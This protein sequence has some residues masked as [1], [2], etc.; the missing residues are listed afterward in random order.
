[1][2]KRSRDTQLSLFDAVPRT[3]PQGQAS[4]PSPS[5]DA[6]DP[7]GQPGVDGRDEAASTA[8]S[9]SPYL[10]PLRIPTAA[11]SLQ[12]AASAFDEHLGRL[13]KTTNTRRAFASDLRLLAEFLGPARALGGISTDDLNRFLTWML[14]YRGEPCSPKTYDR[15]L[16][17]LKV[18]FGWLHASGALPAD[19]SQALVHKRAQAPLQRVLTD[20]EATRLLAVAD[21]LAAGE[22]R[23]PRPAFMLRLLLDTGLKK[24]ELVRLRTD[25]VNLDA[26][27]PSVLVRYDQPRFARKERRVPVGPKV[28]GLFPAYL[29]RYRPA[30]RLFPWT[31]RNLEYVLADLAQTAGLGDDVS[32]ETLRWTA[33]LRAWRSGLATDELRDHLGLSPITWMETEKKLRL[34]ADGLGAMGVARWFD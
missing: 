5:R 20:R 18:L 13:A 16:T 17:T 19:P 1:M 2:N 26:N 31:D 23:D 7:T 10:A 6:G 32:F 3:M 9:P 4:A 27:P 15:R 25:D 34:L 24:G 12:A 29:L 11:T 30:E 28:A 33:A 14:E 8:V 22:A 21:S